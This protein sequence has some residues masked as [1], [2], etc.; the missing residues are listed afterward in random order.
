M[1][2]QRMEVPLICGVMVE[3]IRR[4]CPADLGLWMGARG[5]GDSVEVLLRHGM[6]VQLVRWLSFAAHWIVSV[7][8]NCHSACD[9]W[10]QD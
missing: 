1:E 9:P 4:L 10:Q 6:V 5:D 3:R 7:L 8:G 2:S